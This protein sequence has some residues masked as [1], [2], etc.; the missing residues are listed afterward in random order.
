L[1]FLRRKRT[2]QVLCRNNSGSFAI[3]AAMRRASFLVSNFAA[4]RRPGFILEIDIR[5]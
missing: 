1:I 2:D 4:D 5:E 3:L